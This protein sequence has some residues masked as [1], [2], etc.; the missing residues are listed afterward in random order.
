MPCRVHFLLNCLVDEV[1]EEE[2]YT[3]WERKFVNSLALKID[4][5]SVP[6]E[7]EEEKLEEIWKKSVAGGDEE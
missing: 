5:G 1:D 3:D 7:R 6:S 2:M 4:R